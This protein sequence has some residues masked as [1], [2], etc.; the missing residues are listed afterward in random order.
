MGRSYEEP[1]RKGAGS[2]S[3][4]PACQLF[5]ADDVAS[6]SA[7][8]QDDAVTIAFVYR[9]FVLLRCGERAAGTIANE[10]GGKSHPSE[11]PKKVTE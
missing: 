5:S 2:R 1:K 7:K 6:A 8:R 11:R 4:L 3:D 10:S 9:V